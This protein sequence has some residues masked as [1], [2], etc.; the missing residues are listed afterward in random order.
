MGLIATAGVEVSPSLRMGKVDIKTPPWC[1]EVEVGCG[2]QGWEPICT[3]LN[4][5]I[6]NVPYPNSNDTHEF[7]L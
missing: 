3:F 1:D 5:P 6:P 2:G 7:Q 4:K